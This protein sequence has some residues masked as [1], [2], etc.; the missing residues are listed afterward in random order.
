MSTALWSLYL[1]GR[2]VFLGLPGPARAKDDAPIFSSLPP[3]SSPPSPAW[4]RGLGL[5]CF[6]LVVAFLL[7]ASLMKQIGLGLAGMGGL[8]GGGAGGTSSSLASLLHLQPVHS[9]P[10]SASLPQ[11]G[12]ETGSHDIFGTDSSFECFGD[13]RVDSRTCVFRNLYIFNGRS[14]FVVDP[15]VTPPESVVFPTVHLGAPKFADNPWVSHVPRVITRAELQVAVSVA[16]SSQRVTLDT[17]VFLYQR[18]NPQNIY[19]H[20]WDDVMTA[21]TAMAEAYPARLRPGQGPGDVQI[22]FTDGYP[23][24]GSPADDAWKALGTAD[25]MNARALA[26]RGTEGTIVMVRALAAGSQGRCTHRRHCAVDMTPAQVKAYRNHLLAFYGIV[27]VL[28]PRPTAI[29]IARAKRRM[30]V[31]IREIEGV[32]RSMG[33]ETR[34]IGPFEGASLPEQLREI[35][36]ASLAVFLH[37]AELG[38]AWM[39]LPEG[40]CASVIFPFHFSDTISWW[41]ADKL[42][43]RVA[44]YFDVPSREGDPRLALPIEKEAESIRNYNMDIT[45]VPWMLRNSMWCAK[46]HD[47][48]SEGV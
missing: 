43:I 18:L 47:F 27:T 5:L 13:A 2:A 1:R 21:F 36:N 10:A 26:T 9:A 39:G 14:H 33:Y 31:N 34:V 16:S 12:V 25:V 41:V 42:G 15:S 20:L 46:H 11:W 3:S 32:V 19:H 24:A 35:A 48:I 28:P 37:G 22:V 45:A 8:G 6:C 7:D 38:N 40:A 17:P 29:L 30:F 44:P 23:L 4:R